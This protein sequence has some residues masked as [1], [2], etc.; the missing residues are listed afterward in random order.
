MKNYKQD[1]VYYLNSVEDGYK[2][3]TAECTNGEQTWYEAYS[4][5]YASMPNIF[6]TRDEM[7]KYYD[8]WMDELNTNPEDKP[9]RFKKYERINF[10][11]TDVS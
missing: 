1:D 3:T 5:F 2:V 6:Q 10:R 11:L 7:D 8:E 9:A 4:N